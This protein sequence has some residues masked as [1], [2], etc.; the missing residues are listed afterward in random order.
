ME[1]ILEASTPVEVTNETKVI[2]GPRGYSSYEIAVQHGFVGSELEWLTSLVGAKGEDGKAGSPGVGIIAITKI[3]TEGLVDT[4]QIDYSNGTKSTYTITNGAKG[5]KGDTGEKGEAGAK[6]DKGDKGDTGDTGKSGVYVGSEEP[7]YEDYNVWI[8]P[9][10]SP[11][12]IDYN[13]LTNKPV[14]NLVGTEENPVILLDLSD[15]LYNISGKVKTHSSEEETGSFNDMIYVH[16]LASNEMEY[17]LLRPLKTQ[18][19]YS[20]R[21]NYA[22]YTV[23][24]GLTISFEYL[25]SNGRLSDALNN[26][27]SYVVAPSYSISKTYSVGD[28]VTY[29]GVLQQCVTKIETPE[30]FDDSKW[31]LITVLDA[32][33]NMVSYIMASSYSVLKTYNIGT[34][35]SHNS[36]LYVC[37]T[38]ITT[39]EE[40]DS[41]KWEEVI[42]T[43]WVTG[44]L[45]AATQDKVSSESITNIV[46]L[47]QTEYNN[48]DTKDTN[49]MYLIIEES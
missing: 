20:C 13:A 12:A 26:M 46:K 16:K 42:L 6:G 4:Y 5:D 40:F 14:T 35:V 41:S 23:A 11:D 2:R 39:P 1:V 27:L 48:L 28:Y 19:H 36:K 21:V 38:A 32:I 24:N 30:A 15:G 44:N 45:N 34:I 22:K 3:K 18:G 43:D 49:T 10:G 33:D 8:D 29:M 37:Q 7:S 9:D 25:I 17:L 31:K 47:T